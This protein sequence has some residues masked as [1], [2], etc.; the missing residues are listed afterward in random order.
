MLAYSGSSD[1]FVSVFPI[2]D[3]LNRVRDYMIPEEPHTIYTADGH[4]QQRVGTGT[5]YSAAA[6]VYR[7]CIV[8][9]HNA[10]VVHGLGRH[11]LLVPAS[12]ERGWLPFS[13]KLGHAWRSR[14]L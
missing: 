11:L 5:I 8:I 7:R 13:T 9:H 10:F 2:R 4:Q 14:P 6:D 1:N 12:L 3:L